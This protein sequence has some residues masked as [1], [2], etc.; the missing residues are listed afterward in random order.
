[1]KY[2]TW[3]KKTL[4]RISI[5]SADQNTFTYWAVH[6]HPRG[7][8]LEAPVCWAKQLPK[9]FRL[10]P[11]NKGKNLIEPTN[12]NAVTLCRAGCTETSAEMK[13][14]VFSFWRWL[15][16]SSRSSSVLQGTLESTLLLDTLARHSCL[17]LLLDTLD[18][19]ILTGHSCLTL[20]LDTLSWHSCWTLL[21]ET[22]AWHSFLTLFARHSLLDTLC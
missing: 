1:M 19:T 2:W 6:N 18:G 10:E 5:K 12:P 16:Q 17:T 13:I 22:L 9:L 14:L 11:V 15:A 3:P 7:Q 4:G 21:L 20:F 8:L